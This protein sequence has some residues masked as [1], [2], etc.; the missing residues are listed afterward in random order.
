MRTAELQSIQAL[1]AIAATTVILV[2]IPYI[3]K[4]AFGVDIFFVIS[5]FIM[6]Y[7]S[8]EN[9]DDFLLKRVFRIVPLYW[10]GTMGVF[11]LALA[12]PHLL[13][14]TRASA[15]HLV[16]SL[17][18]IPYIREDGRVYPMLFLGWTLEY[19]M[20]FYLIFGVALALFKKWAALASSLVLLLIVAA[21]TVFQASATIPRFYSNPLMIE[22]VLGMGLFWLWKKYRAVLA[23][24]PAGAAIAIVVAGYVY[25]FFSKMGYD[26]RPL[27]QGLPALVIVICSL[28]LEGAMRFPIWILA[29][30][31][32]SYSLYLFH[33]YVVQ[34]LD[35]KVHSL[36]VL[37]PV[38]ALMGIIGVLACFLVALVSFRLIEKPSN[39]ALRRL[40]T[41]K[42]G[43]TGRSPLFAPDVGSGG[44]SRAGRS[45]E[46][47]P[48]I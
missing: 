15:G 13:T 1:R 23:K 16:K 44:E 32:A 47:L 8:A 36:A 20:F 37:T 45:A 14:G 41:T 9:S 29:I 35:K 26:Y 2:H 33:P 21:G 40:L 43:Q 11:F 46:V 3:G 25:L 28:S 30:G 7:I 48:R 4:G 39:R 12:A 38:S 5:G 34:L 17:F 31:D 27:V 42:R 10:L 22:F 18:L 6:C 24:L 19:E